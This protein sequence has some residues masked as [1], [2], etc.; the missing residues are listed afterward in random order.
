[1]VIIYFMYPFLTYYYYFYNYLSLIECEKYLFGLL[2]HVGAFL[3]SQNREMPTRINIV[4]WMRRQV[5]YLSTHPPT[6]R[7][8]Q[9]TATDDIT[10]VHAQPTPNE[11][12]TANK[13]K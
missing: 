4:N 6:K 8:G 7:K 10:K 13:I 2:T 5:A 9:S 1:M 3:R 12:I 11:Y